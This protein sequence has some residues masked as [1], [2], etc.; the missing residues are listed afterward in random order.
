MS[1][2]QYIFV[3]EVL[4]IYIYVYVHSFSTSLTISIPQVCIF[5]KK[6]CAQFIK[7]R[8]NMRPSNSP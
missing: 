7:H 2:Y 3:R 8:I 1:I 5:K 6:I 4:P